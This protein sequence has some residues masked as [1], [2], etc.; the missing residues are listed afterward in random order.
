MSD[1]AGWISPSELSSQLQRITQESSRGLA[2]YLGSSRAGNHKRDSG[3]RWRTVGKPG[4]GSPRNMSVWCHC[5]T[6][7]SFNT[8]TPHLEV[9]RG[10]SG[11]G[12]RLRASCQAGAF[13]C[14][15][16]SKR[17]RRQFILEA[18]AAV[19]CSETEWCWLVKED[20]PL[21][22]ASELSYHVFICLFSV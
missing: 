1:S 20:Y 4:L 15:F 17:L 21:G 7:I 13:R 22:R 18:G 10:E 6:G 12:K 2:W 11:F 8:L 5:S 14:L 16:C 9:I 19:L 3:T